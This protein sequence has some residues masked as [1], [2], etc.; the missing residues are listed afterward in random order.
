MN[1]LV[2]VS[3]VIVVAMTTPWVASAVP[4]YPSAGQAV[5]DGYY[6]EWDLTNDYFAD[7][8][9]AG[10][11]NK[12]VESELYLRY[13]CVSNTLYALVLN[14]P[15]VVGYIDST[16]VTSWIAIDDNSNKVVNEASGNDGIPPDFAWIDRGYD[17]DPQHVRGYEASF[18]LYPGSYEIYAHTDIWDNNTQTSATAGCPHTGLEIVAEP[19]AGEATSFGAIKALYR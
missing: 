1:R 18:I 14:L 8:Y 5:V 15:D 4:P 10:N 13:D 2:L 3:G 19:S 12:P 7:M 11:P 9:R 16:A 6:A 17:G